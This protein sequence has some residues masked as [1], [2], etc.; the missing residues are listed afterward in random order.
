MTSKKS[1]LTINPTDPDC[2]FT[3]AA[4]DAKSDLDQTFDTPLRE[5]TGITSRVQASKSVHGL[6]MKEA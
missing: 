1:A 6:L 3:I 5:I 4:A 2:M